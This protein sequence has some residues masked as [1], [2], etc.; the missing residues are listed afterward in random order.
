MSNM[1]TLN[2]GK[3]PK[4]DRNCICFETV[5]EIG[6]HSESCYFDYVYLVILA[7]KCNANFWKKKYTVS[8]HSL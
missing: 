8:K 2:V 7:M 5:L 4:R 1:A 3:E 6:A